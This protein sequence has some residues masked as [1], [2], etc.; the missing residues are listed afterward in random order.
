MAANRNGG[1]LRL[2]ASRH[3]DDD[4]DDDDEL[5]QTILLVSVANHVDS[6]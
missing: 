2:I 6:L 5:T 1:M 3:D 4:D